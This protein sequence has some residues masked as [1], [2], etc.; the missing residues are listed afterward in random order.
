MTR[1]L[2]CALALAAVL[3]AFAAPAF[4]GGAQPPTAV[5]EPSSILLLAGGLA[6]VI[7]I[8]TRFAKK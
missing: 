1:S 2:R 6:A 8:R 4:A 7:G 3:V 5:P